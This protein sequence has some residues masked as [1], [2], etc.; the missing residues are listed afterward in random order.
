MDVSSSLMERLLFLWSPLLLALWLL[1][2]L[3]LAI[4]IDSG[5]PRRFTLASLLLGVAICSLEMAAMFWFGPKLITSGILVAGITAFLPTVLVRWIPRRT[6][7]V[8]Q[9]PIIADV[10]TGQVEDE[11]R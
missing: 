11:R 10:A 7:A 5:W 3:C 4:W 2:W 6:R 1:P 8:R 9:P